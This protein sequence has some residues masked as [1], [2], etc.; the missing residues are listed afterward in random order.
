MRVFVE[1]VEDILCMKATCKVLSLTILGGSSAGELNG[2]T[3]GGA[4]IR[5]GPRERCV[6]GSAVEERHILHDR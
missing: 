4:T 2:G 6:P 3:I 1:A 5:S